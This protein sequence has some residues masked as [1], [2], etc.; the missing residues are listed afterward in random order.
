[1]VCVGLIFICLLL[2]VLFFG[3]TIAGGRGHDRQNAEWARKAAEA[4]RTDGASNSGGSP[5]TTESGRAP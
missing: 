2:L 1:M 3:V 5:D 4:D